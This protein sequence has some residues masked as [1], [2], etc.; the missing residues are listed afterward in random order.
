MSRI[1]ELTAALKDA[2]SEA[3]TFTVMR[4]SLCITVISLLLTLELFS[5]D[6]PAV[7][8][9]FITAEYCGSK[10]SL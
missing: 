7:C 1:I 4:L 6:V 5:A 8:F 3:D 10:R 2:T 9:K